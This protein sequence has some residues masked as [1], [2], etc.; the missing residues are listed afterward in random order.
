MERGIIIT[1]PRHDDV[2]DYI[3]QFS[4]SIIK[5]A[6]KKNV[7]V[8]TIKDKEVNKKDFE[9]VVKKLDYNMIIFNGHGSDKCIYGYKNKILIECDVNDNLLNKKITYA[10]VCNAGA[11]LGEKYIK[12]K[13]GCFI[14]YKLPFM[15]YIN[16]NRISKPLSDHTAE[17]FIEPSNLI[18]I[19]L[20]KGNT[21]IEAHESSKTA[22]LKNIN[23]VLRNKDK[24]HYL[25]AEALWNNYVGQV[26]LGNESIKL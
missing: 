13:H 15:F 4:R 1:L 24:E 16:T 14:G 22:I 23:K 3:S 17:L 6:D 20:I 12:D 19:S 9:K 21:A 5:E 11:T 25:I 2:T 26:I 7:N 8:K 10:R 18:P